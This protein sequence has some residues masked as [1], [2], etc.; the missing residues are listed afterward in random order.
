MT[1]KV[2]IVI[3]LFNNKKSK[4]MYINNTR[5]GG[6][7]PT[8]FNDQELLAGFKIPIADIESAIN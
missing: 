4:A 6:M 3:Y 1:K 5:V 8:G 2:D 7:N